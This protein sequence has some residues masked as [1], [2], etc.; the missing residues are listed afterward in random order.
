MI[1]K[2]EI[3]ALLQQQED[4]R[5]QYHERGKENIQSSSVENIMCKA[6]P[7]W[8]EGGYANKRTVVPGETIAFYLAS[9]IQK[10]NATFLKLQGS[11]EIDIF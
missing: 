2:L 1:L 10:F 11:K 5:R 9:E 7:D 4:L 8:C 3:T 6:Y